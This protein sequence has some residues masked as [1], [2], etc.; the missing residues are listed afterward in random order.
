MATPLVRAGKWEGKLK[1]GSRTECEKER[2]EFQIDQKTFFLLEPLFSFRRSVYPA[3]PPT[4]PSLSPSLFFKTKMA[5]AWQAH[6]YVGGSSKF[7]TEGQPHFS[8]EN[9]MPHIYAAQIIVCHF[10]RSD[11]KTDRRLSRGDLHKKPRK[12][13][14]ICFAHHRPVASSLLSRIYLYFILLIW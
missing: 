11:G 13:G 2:L 10:T 8:F 5:A 12:T 14:R 7:I 4:P 6:Y 3:H 1:E 9:Q